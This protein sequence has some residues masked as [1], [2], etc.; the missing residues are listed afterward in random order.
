M[1]SP[2]KEIRKD[3]GLGIEVRGT[4]DGFVEPGVRRRPTNG[5]D[6]SG[7]QQGQRRKHY[8]DCHTEEN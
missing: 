6:V 8:Q 2:N 7:K 3:E 4:S 1:V 5:K